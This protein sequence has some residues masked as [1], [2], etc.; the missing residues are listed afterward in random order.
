MKKLLL[1]LISFIPA[2]T[3]SQSPD[4]KT[5]EFI[6]PGGIMDT[7]FD[8][9][10]NKYHISK[11]LV[12]SED[13]QNG[14]NKS[15][16]SVNSCTAGMFVVD[17]ANGS[18]MESSSN[19]IHST[20]RQ[21]VCEVLSNISGLLGYNSSYPNA[22]LIKILVDDV[23]PYTAPIT[24]SASGVLGMATAFY[25]VP[26][27]PA[28][29][30]P[31]I[32]ENVIER[33]IKSRVNAWTNIIS[34]MAPINGNSFYHGMMAFNF[35]S[36]FVTWNSGIL[37]TATINEYDLYTVILH[38]VTHALGFASLIN[39]NGLSKFGAANN[40]YS[41][42]DKYLNR[43][44]GS[45]LVPLLNSGSSCTSYGLT[46][47]ASPSVLAPGCSSSY[48]TD[49]STCTTTI[50]YN[51]ALLPNMPLYTP[52]CFEGGS[53]LSHFEDMCFP[54]NNPANNNLYFSMSNANGQGTNKRYLK[55]EEKKVLCDLGYTVTNTYTSNA[56]SATYTYSGG[57]YSTSPVWGVN[58][59]LNNNAYLYT[60][61]GG[62]IS[63]PITGSSG[64]I[65]NDYQGSNPVTTITCVES[66]YN[67]GTAVV[68]GNTI[69]FTPNSTNGGIF[70]IRYVPNNSSALKG[71]I[72]YI[73][74][75][76]Y[77]TFCGSVTPCDMVQNGGFENNSGCGS[78]PIGSSTLASCWLVSSLS[79]DVFVRNCTALSGALSTPLAANLGSNTYSSNP[80]FNSFNGAPN[81]AVM[82]IG[83]ATASSNE[84]HY[85]ESLTNYLGSPIINNQAYTLSFWAY[86]FVG[87][88]ADPQFDYN[89]ANPLQSFNTDSISA[90][91]TFATDSNYIPVTIA[92][93][94]PYS[95][96]ISIQSVTLA[97]AFN[98]WK[99]YTVTFT[100]TA[101]TVGNWLYVGMDKNLTY[102]NIINTIGNPTGGISFYT[103][104]DDISLRPTNQAP[105]L[106]MPSMICQGQSLLNLGQYVN[107]SGGIFS[108]IGITSSVTST[109]NGLVTLYNFNASQSMSNGLYTIIYTYTDNINC[110]QTAIQQIN[111]GN[112]FNGASLAYASTTNCV[113]GGTLSVLSPSAAYNYTWQ[114]GNFSGNNYTVSANSITNYTV[115]GSNNS[116]CSISGS[117]SVIPNIP[118]AQ[119]QVNPQPA[120][121]GSTSQ[122]NAIGNYTSVLWQPGSFTT[123]IINISPSMPT[124]YTAYLSGNYGCANSIN[125]L[126]LVG[127]LP[128]LNIAVSS[129]SICSSQPSTLT[130]S[131]AL[132]YSWSNAATSSVNIVY[133]ATTTV[134]TLTGTGSNSCATNATVMVKVYSPSITISGSNE[135][136]AGESITLSAQSGANTYA[137]LPINLYSSVITVTPAVSTI[138]SVHAT[139]FSSGNTC[140]GTN[141]I[142]INVNLCKG[143]DEQKPLTAQFTIFPNPNDG[144]FT[145]STEK[146][147]LVEI[148]I[149]NEAGQTI[150]ELILDESNHHKLTISDLLTGFYFVES[151]GKHS[152]LIITK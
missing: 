8:R 87:S 127:N 36:P 10:G 43:M 120:C 42:Y 104:I 22:A 77:P 96:L 99:H 119:L 41:S 152:K 89:G 136:C 25:V 75:F 146:E 12:H 85:S 105:Q 62:P 37:N 93:N 28:S 106:N 109:S 32:T 48:T 26:W 54:T 103:L 38:E 69:V 66:V 76:V 149:Y 23:A 129:S 134:Y 74:G 15:V 107:T 128:T 102:A 35:A 1:L 24:P 137:W 39:S 150:K 148:K 64:V 31:G 97:N 60:S 14:E 110:V 100:N 73:F 51:S 122:I 94:Y 6:T 117:I 61:T 20:R 130:A 72:T 108:G 81:N 50:K 19:P 47:T 53:S 4:T 56:A 33:T 135:I 5:T 91:L 90:V 18:G 144:T 123:N 111:I 95:P 11:L 132:S 140:V 52:A 138:Y 21:T 86:Q 44:V 9:F 141:T 7:I 16:S 88:K 112:H 151:E 2:I 78:M 143:I 29:A 133:P 115:F 145:I 79:P 118:H 67:N 114:P 121:I 83:A 82:G 147:K 34:P 55:S 113:N 68:S 45:T 30:N 27:N 98:V 40:Y 126:V 71:N 58:D 125:T 65:A 84:L 124:T 63:I 142:Q 92:S 131:G 70:V 13:N 59:G 101:L 80:V 57:T 139:V 3:Y 46:F 17:F 116:T 49:I